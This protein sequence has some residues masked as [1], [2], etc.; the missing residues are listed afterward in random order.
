M[1]RLIT[2]KE[3]ARLTG[4]TQIGIRFFV[5]QGILKAYRKSPRSQLRFKERDLENFMQSGSS[6][7]S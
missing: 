4:Y 6:A 2:T 3:A 7:K 5:K 1:E